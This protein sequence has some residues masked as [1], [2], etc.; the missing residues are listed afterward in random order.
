MYAY[1]KL[2]LTQRAPQSI[3]YDEYCS[4]HWIY[5]LRQLAA[6]EVLPSFAIRLKA[7]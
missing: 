4:T 1:H 3:R 7:N 5:M 2:L 6:W